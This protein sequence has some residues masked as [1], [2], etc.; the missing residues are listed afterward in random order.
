MKKYIIIGLLTLIVISLWN[1]EKDDLCPRT[2]PT[3]SRVVIEF[4][5]IDEPNV[6]KDVTN[7]KIQEVDS[8]EAIIANP[9]TTDA[10][11]YLFNTN[12]VLIPLKTNALE[13][14]FNFTLNS[15]ATTQS[16]NLVTFS[17]AKE[18]IYISRA[19]GYK[20]NFNITNQTDLTELASGT[21]NFWIKFYEV[22]QPSIE[23][24]NETHVKIYF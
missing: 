17:Y 13:S 10:A 22:I 6:L 2:I 4:Y 15:G 24:E 18:D 9:N 16:T 8:D 3:T 23:N 19:C 5:D 12:K 7:L 1:C 20:T 14:N 11:K 21:N